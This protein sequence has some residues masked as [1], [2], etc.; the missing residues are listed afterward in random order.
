MLQYD[1]A[2]CPLFSEMLPSEIEVFVEHCVSD[3]KEFEKGEYVVRQG[4]PINHLYL[5]VSGLVRTAMLTRDDNILEIETLAPVIPLAPAFL[6]A[7]RNIFPVDVITLEPTVLF[8]IPRTTLQEEMMRNAKL[9]QNML[10]INANMIVFLSQ[11][12]QMLSIR[13]LR[14]KLAIYLLENTSEEQNILH[15]HRTQ[16]QLAEYFGVQRPSLSRTLGEMVADGAIELSRQEI[17]VCNR[18]KLR[19][20]L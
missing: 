17:V 7:N 14:M 5:L 2:S 20:Y 12:V 1:L 4:T 15:L 19:S 13:S 18:Q 3:I 16:S 6:F 8:L 9:L 10:R 11:K